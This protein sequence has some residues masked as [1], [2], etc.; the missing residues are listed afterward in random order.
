MTN[1]K[2]YRLAHHTRS[3]LRI[4]TGCFHFQKHSIIINMTGRNKAIIPIFSLGIEELT[5][6]KVLISGSKALVRTIS[7]LPSTQS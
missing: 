2:Y 3:Y 6:T 4:I 7:K 1:Q 5:H